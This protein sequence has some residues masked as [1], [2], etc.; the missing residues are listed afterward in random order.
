MQ[1]WASDLIL[2]VV[3]VALV[4]AAT[5]IV[6][7]STTKHVTCTAAPTTLSGATSCQATLHGNLTVTTLTAGNTSIVGWTSDAHC[8]KTNATFTCTNHTER[9]N[10]TVSYRSITGEHDVSY[11]I[12]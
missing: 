11:I 8:T 2:I 9:T 10:L 1:S 4:A 12:R 5:N 6:L 7:S 3:S